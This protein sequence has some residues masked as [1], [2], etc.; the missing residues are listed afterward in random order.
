MNIFKKILDD[1][2]KSKIEVVP[3]DPKDQEVVDQ[4]NAIL[5]WIQDSTCPCC[6][7]EKS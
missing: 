7:K 3:N 5:K 1:L 6:K 2:P 4:I